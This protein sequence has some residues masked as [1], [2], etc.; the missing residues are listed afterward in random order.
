MTSIAT[1]IN[2]NASHLV[3]WH[4]VAL[5][6]KKNPKWY[7]CVVKKDN[8]DG[9]VKVQWD[10]GGKF[11]KQLPVEKFRPDIQEVDEPTDVAFDVLFKKEE[12]GD[13]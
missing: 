5:F 13:Y 10:D 6:G 11:T 2:T 1:S 7:P 3:G 12:D 4:G 9:T 8:Q